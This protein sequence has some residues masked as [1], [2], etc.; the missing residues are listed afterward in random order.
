MTFTTDVSQV[1]EAALDRG[2]GIRLVGAAEPGQHDT[3]LA[4][5]GLNSTRRRELPGHVVIVTAW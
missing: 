3:L 5:P 2:V 4:W 1:L